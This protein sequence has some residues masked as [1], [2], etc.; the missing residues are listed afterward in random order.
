MTYRSYGE[1]AARVS[2]ESQMDAAPGVA[3]LVGHVSPKFR[4]PGMRDTDNVKVF[5]EEF[6]QYEKNFDSPNPRQALAEFHR[7]EPSR[8]SHARNAC[9][10][11]TRRRAMVANNDWAVGQ[12]GGSRDSLA[13]LAGNGDFHH[14][15]RR[16]ERAGSRGCAANGGAGHQPLHQTRNRLIRHCTQLRRCCEQWNCCS[17]FHP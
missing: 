8:K 14:R 3:G 9:R 15:R 11:L 7:D 4:L 16:A 2:D 6:E 13:L 1:Y 12:A 10:G 5:L 17:G